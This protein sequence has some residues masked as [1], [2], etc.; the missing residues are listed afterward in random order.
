MDINTWDINLIAA[1]GLYC[2]ECKKYLEEKC[3]GCNQNKAADKWCKIKTCCKQNGYKS[4]A[5]CEKEDNI[6]KCKKFNN[7]FSKIFKILFN[8]DR[9]YCI[10]LIKKSGYKEFAEKMSEL[11]D[12]NGSK[13]KK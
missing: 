8:S 4:C 6:M 11:K 9:K 7:I 2:K 5:D 10:D 13:L 1:C 12:Y 3:D